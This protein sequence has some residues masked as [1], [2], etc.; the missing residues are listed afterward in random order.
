MLRTRIITALILAPLAVAGVFF[1]PTPAFAIVFWGAAALG[2]YEWSALMGLKSGL[3]RG[4]W[5][6]AYAGLC[7]LLW[8]MPPWREVMIYLDWMLWGLA[9]LL[10]LSYPLGSRLLRQPLVLGLLGLVLFA[11]GWA[12]LVRIHMHPDGG[13][14][15][16][17]LFLL[18]WGADIGAY[19]AGKALGRHKLAPAV[20]P[21]K[22][23]EG[24]AGGL[25]T[26]L[27]VCSA[28][29]LLWRA[30]VGIWLGGIVI[31]V[32]V[33]VL[34][35]LFESAVK[36]STGVKDSGTLLPGHGGVLDRIDSLLAVLPF[37]A[38]AIA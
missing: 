36:R 32:G 14:W 37:F 6:L 2:A 7:L 20:S 34:G 9:L 13:L 25:L 24:C 19:F 1:L 28:M 10:V 11:G 23:W 5:V 35:D 17:W 29:L 18:V 8:W 30:E 16:V 15:F 31:L 26:A 4:I 3:A 27:V 33:S 38:I 21:G 22:T 12:S